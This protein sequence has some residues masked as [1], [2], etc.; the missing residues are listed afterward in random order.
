MSDTNRTPP[1]PVNEGI[2]ATSVSAE[3]MAVGRNARAFQSTEHASSQQELLQAVAQLRQGLESLQLQAHAKAAVDEDMAK[4]QS[5][6]ES[7]DHKADHAGHILE[8][9]S[10]KLKMVGVVLSEAVHLSEP[11]RK[12][13]ELLHIPL[14]LLG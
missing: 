5:A 11:L 7:R 14:H 4:L 6:A 13:A 12:I 3:V 8:S 9:L 10:G 2:Q 1:A